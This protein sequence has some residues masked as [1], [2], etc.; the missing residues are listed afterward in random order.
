MG[1]QLRPKRDLITIILDPGQR[2]QIREMAEVE[3]RTLNNYLRCLISR[4]WEAF[5][6]K[7]DS[8]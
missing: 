8:Q 1:V 3:K 5:K 2:D 6:G 4:A 7:E